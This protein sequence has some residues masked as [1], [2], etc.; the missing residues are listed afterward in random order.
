MRLVTT[1]KPPVVYFS[2]FLYF[3][4]QTQFGLLSE[5]HHEIKIEISRQDEPAAE[6]EAEPEAEQQAEPKTEGSRPRDQEAT[7]D[8]NEHRPDPP[9][10]PSPGSAARHGCR[11][12]SWPLVDGP[13]A[14]LN[15]LKKPRA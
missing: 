9:I 11:S 6:P 3:I 4:F 14:V 10:S 5:F 12:G 15:Y 8:E 1:C 13:N 2:Y 7:Q